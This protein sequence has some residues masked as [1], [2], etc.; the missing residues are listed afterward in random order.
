MGRD[1]K[2]A[3]LSYGENDRIFARLR[4]ATTAQLHKELT[5]DNA[6]ELVDCAARRGVV[7]AQIRLGRMLLD[8]AGIPADPASALGWFL[9]AARAHD[10]EAMNMVGRCFENGWGTEVDFVQAARWYERAARRGDAWAQYNLGH[11]YLDGIGVFTDRHAALCW[12]RRAAHAGHPR[13][14]NLVGRCLEQGWGNAC[15]PAAAARWYAR[16][17][18]GGYFRGQYNH[19]SMLAAAGRTEEAASWYARAAEG[20]TDAVRAAIVRELSNHADPGLRELALRLRAAER[21]RGGST[22][23]DAPDAGK[24]CG[25]PEGAQRVQPPPRYAAWHKRAGVKLII[26]MI[27]NLI[28]RARRHSHILPGGS[29]SGLRSAANDMPG[30]GPS[31]AD[32]PASGHIEG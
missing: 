22:P 26:Q 5:G 11:C 20:A 25:F 10:P 8:G 4:S 7:E 3:G 28:L 32:A 30:A 31:D 9:T 17:A 14:M 13:A 23:A 29:R 12:Y 27:R 21:R 16:S 19:A 18:A 2:R 1:L 24:A 6:F 15:D